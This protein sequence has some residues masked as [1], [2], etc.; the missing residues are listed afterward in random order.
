MTDADFSPKYSITSMVL[1]QEGDQ[2][3]LYCKVLC[4]DLVPTLGLSEFEGKA[5]V[6]NYVVEDEDLEWIK[7]L[8]I[9]QVEQDLLSLV[10]ET[11]S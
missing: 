3:Y 7:K 9:K 4:P 6:P 1:K 10:K 11:S 2:R 5:I 8:V